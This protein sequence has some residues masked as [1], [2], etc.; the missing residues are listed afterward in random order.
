MST[1]SYTERAN[2]VL[3]GPFDPVSRR[4]PQGTCH[5][6]IKALGNALFVCVRGILSRLFCGPHLIDTAT[7]C[8]CACVGLVFQVKLSFDLNWNWEWQR[9][10]SARAQALSAVLS[11]HGLEK[12]A[13]IMNPVTATTVP[14][15]P[16]HSVHID[17]RLWVHVC[18]CM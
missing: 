6:H 12:R 14:I 18:A 1:S 11:H 4:G 8:H 5:I 17:C 7:G 16:Q 2:P 9:P 3:D 15:S 13:H 10:G